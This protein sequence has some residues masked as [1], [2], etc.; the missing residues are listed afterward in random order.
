MAIGV[1]ILTRRPRVRRGLGGGGG[2]L[3]SSASRSRGGFG[4]R[5]CCV[6]RSGPTWGTAEVTSGFGRDSRGSSRPFSATNLLVRS[7]GASGLR[8]GFASL[9]S[10]ASGAAALPSFSMVVGWST[11]GRRG[12]LKTAVGWS[13]GG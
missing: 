9:G 10:A 8:G 1:Q 13:T 4:G 5:G 2:V 11:G 6:V 3:V 7:A 12:A